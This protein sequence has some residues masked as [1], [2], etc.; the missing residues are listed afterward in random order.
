MQYEYW[1][2]TLKGISNKRKQE[3]RK[4]I[5]SAEL[6]YNIEET[7]LRKHNFQETEYKII[8]ENT[9]NKTINKEYEKLVGE[10]IACITMSDARYPKRLGNIPSAPYALF[11]K[12]E[13]PE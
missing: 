4:R 8:L 3:I 1:F 6:L 9:N 5:P 13:L 12:G 10:G 2:A 7:E 11:V